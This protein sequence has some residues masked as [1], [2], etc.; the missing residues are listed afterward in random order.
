MLTGMRRTECSLIEKSWI[1]EKQKT[2][3]IPANVTK[4]GRAHTILLSNTSLPLAIAL[5]RFR[6]TKPYTNWSKSKD[7]LDAQSGVDHWCLHDIRR[8]VATNLAALGVRIEVTEKILN[9]VSGKLSGVARVYNRHSYWDEQVEALAKWETKL[10]K[11]V[12]GGAP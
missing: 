11:I 6:S 8:T 7:Q 10:Q 12:H 5:A 1:N 9:H 4:N 2:L 3:T